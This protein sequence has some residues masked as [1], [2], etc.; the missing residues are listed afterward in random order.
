MSEKKQRKN[1]LSLSQKAEIISKLD[2][3]VMAKRLA[4][5]YGVAESTITYI[6]GQKSKILEAVASASHDAKKKSLHK[7]PNEQME[8]QLYKWFEL[9]RSKNCPLSA[10]II[11]AKAKTIF[12]EMHPEK[13]DNAF[14]ASNGWFENFKRRYGI[15][16]LAIGGEKLSADLSQIT[17]YT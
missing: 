14:V 1:T 12:T 6:K 15:R 17:E 2:R 3:G 11:K 8:Q 5:E 16:L 9:Q 10:D 4:Q 13:D 7:A